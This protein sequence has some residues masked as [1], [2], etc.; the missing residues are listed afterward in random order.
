VIR[1]LLALLLGL[2]LAGCASKPLVREDA[3]GPRLLVTI[4]YNASDSLHGNPSDRYRR[5][6]SG[7]GAGPNADPVLDALA[8]EYSITRVAGWPMRTLGVH[9]EVYATARGADADAIVAR[10]AHDPRV[11]SAE[12]MRQFRTLTQAADP[13]RPLQHAL[14][15]LEV[16]AAHAMAS[17]AGV[18]V[19]VIDSG[20]DATHRD[21]SGVVRA[22]RNFTSGAPGP[23]GTEVA[24]IIAARQHNGAG[25]MGVAPAAELVDL[26]ACS[27]GS[28]P[29]APAD[30][31]SYTLA[32]ALDFA[33]ASGVDVINLS[34]AG[35]DDPL[36]ARLLGQAEAQGI[37][38]VAAAPPAGDERDRFPA[39]VITVIAVAESEQ[40][41]PWPASA[42]RAP[43]VDVLTTFPG[44]RYD[45]GSGSSLSS[46]HV[47]GVV[48]LMRSLDRHLTPQQVRSLLSAHHPLSAAA[49][50]KDE[51]AQVAQR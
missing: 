47:S 39:S 44:D 3:G 26:R 36:L 27:G 28:K 17:G 43:G 16:D 30:C 37:S 49:V 1:V 4:R 32:Q 42:V 50:L 9:C 46:A 35:P 5:P 45:Y 51:A 31:D 11:D 7:Y 34:L 41:A 10:L 14:D 19:A 13:Y 20:I 22:Q 8:A 48:A 6:S 38:V 33:V 12:P 40:P 2:V 24:G 23:H 15:T 29:D 18:R 21:L 25:I